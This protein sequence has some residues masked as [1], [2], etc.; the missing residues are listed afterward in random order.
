M[1]IGD[2]SDLTDGQMRRIEMTSDTHDEHNA[3]DAVLLCRVGGVPYAVAGS[4]TEPLRGLCR[5]HSTS[6]VH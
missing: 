4:G 1:H 6:N 5:S 3:V 2:L